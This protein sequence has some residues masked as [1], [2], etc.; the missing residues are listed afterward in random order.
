MRH[1]DPMGV[2]QDQ[3]RQASKRRVTLSKSHR[4]GLKPGALHP[5]PTPW[6]L[7]SV[8][9][10]YHSIGALAVAA[11]EDSFARLAQV[12]KHNIHLHLQEFGNFISDVN[13][14]LCG[15]VGFPFNDNGVPAAGDAREPHE[16]GANGWYGMLVQEPRIRRHMERNGTQDLNEV[17]LNT[18]QPPK[19]D[20]H[21]GPEVV[22]SGATE[23]DREVALASV[24]VFAQTSDFGWRKTTEREYEDKTGKIHSWP[25]YVAKLEAG[26]QVASLWQFE[27]FMTLG[28]HDWTVTEFG[29]V[30]TGSRLQDDHHLE[31]RWA[32]SDTADG[33]TQEP[34]FNALNFI[35]SGSTTYPFDKDGRVRPG[36]TRPS[37][38]SFGG[39]MAEMKS[40]V[41]EMRTKGHADHIFPGPFST[42]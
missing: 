31:F 11:L 40:F 6:R 13:F 10:F 16:L 3:F 18:E 2:H 34:L 36:A 15:Q 17:I 24:G 21:I 19:Y 4:A 41:T 39:W 8:E 7:R 35:L 26:H 1:R 20:H 5:S 22:S 12:E 28:W 14:T 42:K 32:Q 29:R 30:V 25:S 9:Q 27:T 37:A 33:G 38:D 23:R